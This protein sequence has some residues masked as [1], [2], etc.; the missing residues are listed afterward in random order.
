MYTALYITELNIKR[1]IWVYLP[2]D[3]AISEKRYPVLYMQDGQNLFDVKTSFSGEWQIDEYLDSVNFAGIVVGIDNGG[4]TRINEYN[5]NNT[6]QHGMGLGRVYL[7]I[8]VTILKPYIDKNFRTISGPGH[9]AM[10]GSSLGGLI[11]FY[12]GLYYPKVF[13]SVGVISPSFWLV[14]DVLAQ[15]DAMPAKGYEQQRYYF[16]GGKKEGENMV[17]LIEAVS[18][19]LEKIMRCKVMVSISETGTHSESSWRKMFPAFYEWLRRK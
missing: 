7:N 17:T 13:G 19:R 10:A 12:A 18:S 16:Y 9:T 1:R 11:S 2:G 4:E 14:P 5:P 6:E 15:I 8:L 3:Y